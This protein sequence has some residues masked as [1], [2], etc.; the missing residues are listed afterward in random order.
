MNFFFCIWQHKR[1]A[2][3]NL[4]LMSVNRGSVVTP[5]ASQAMNLSTAIIV[6]NVNGICEIIP[7]TWT[8]PEISA[9][10]HLL[11]PSLGNFLTLS[12]HWTQDIEAKLSCEP[13]FAHLMSLEGPKMFSFI[14]ICAFRS[15]ILQFIFRN[16]RTCWTDKR[17]LNKMTNFR[18]LTGELALLNWTCTQTFELEWH[19]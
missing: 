18:L 2:G 9:E 4:A 11:C 13:C 5:S 3:I 6:R 1:Q 15:R 12:S 7:V 10:F 8:G 17:P 16:F 19:Y 14:L